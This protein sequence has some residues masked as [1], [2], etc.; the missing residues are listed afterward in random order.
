MAV[1]G[2]DDRLGASAMYKVVERGTPR[3]GEAWSRALRTAGSIRDE[4]K[5]FVIC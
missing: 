1:S 4:C 3:G 5:G 2:L